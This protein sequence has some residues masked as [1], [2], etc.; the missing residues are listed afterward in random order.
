MAFEFKPVKPIET[1]YRGFRF[2]SRLE[3]RWAV[4]FDHIGLVWEYEKEGYKLPSGRQYL[5]DFFFPNF[6]YTGNEYPGGCFIEIKP[7]MPEDGSDD[8]LKIT[9]F[10]DNFESIHHP[11]YLIVGVPKDFVTLY[12]TG[13][14]YSTTYLMGKISEPYLI[15]LLTEEICG[16]LD[17]E[18]YH[19]E[20]PKNIIHSM[21]K[22]LRS[23]EIKDS[24]KAAK[25]A[26]FEFGEAG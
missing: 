13:T 6:P 17:K 19:L 4:F 1:H 20:E 15:A 5:P 21:I 12:K 16:V 26:R 18:G 7:T 25:S 2:R 11:L 9:E 3:A 10:N 14:G 22:G 23:N 24:L 8:W